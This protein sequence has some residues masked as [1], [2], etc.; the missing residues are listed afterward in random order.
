MYVTG[1][2]TFLVSILTR[3][4]VVGSDE[5]L[6]MLETKQFSAKAACTR[7]GWATSLAPQSTLYPQKSKSMAKSTPTSLLLFKSLPM[8]SYS[9]YR[10]NV[11][12]S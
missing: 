3:I 6:N 11:H 9:S 12:I 7:K 8:L 2:H 1:T 10:Y 5:L 4:Q